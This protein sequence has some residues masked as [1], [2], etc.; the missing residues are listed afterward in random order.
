[1]GTSG[2]IAECAQRGAEH[3]Q[4]APPC[5]TDSPRG[6]GRAPDALGAPFDLAHLGFHI[7]P[8][9]VAA[10][11]P[12]CDLRGAPPRF[13]DW[14]N[15]PRRILL[16]LASVWVISVFD[17]GYTLADQG[18]SEFVE[19]NPIAAVLLNGPTHVITA[20]KFGLLGLS[21][22]ILLALRRHT[23]AEL[24]CWFLLAAKLYVAIRWLLYF[25]CL[26][27]GRGN[28]FIGSVTP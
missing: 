8:A 24:A 26:V 10:P 7:V 11:A 13:G 22:A 17:L 12:L 25:D 15:R 4:P 3:S 1:M 21:T 2:A 28:I 27:K 9:P 19:L 6:N 20:F 5:S 14:L 23:I 16:T 18:T